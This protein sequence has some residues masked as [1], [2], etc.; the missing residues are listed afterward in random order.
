[1]SFLGPTSSFCLVVVAVCEL[2]RPGELDGCVSKVKRGKLL[3]EGAGS[4]DGGG[5]YLP[6]D[7]TAS[8]DGDGGGGGC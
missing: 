8:V 4:D 1:M 2:D 6:L 5:S 3:I 7:G